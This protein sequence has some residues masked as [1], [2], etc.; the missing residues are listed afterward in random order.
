VQLC[1]SAGA[2]VISDRG[3]SGLQLMLWRVHGVCFAVRPLPDTRAALPRRLQCGRLTK[4]G[5]LLPGLGSTAALQ[6]PLQG[7]GPATHQHACVLLGLMS[8]LLWPSHCAAWACLVCT[9]HGPASPPVFAWET[10]N[11]LLGAT[12]SCVGSTW[13]VMVRLYAS[14]DAA[15]ISSRGLTWAAADVVRFAVQLLPGTSSSCLRLVW[16]V[17]VDQALQATAWAGQH[18]RHTLQASG[19]GVVT[20]PTL[21]PYLVSCLSCKRGL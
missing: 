19:V 17:H 7:W 1:A 3:Q 4:P 2:A 12:R 15:V 10:G 16:A 13:R 5:W 8:A 18:C 21:H 20:Y 6:H 9:A 11:R 14:A